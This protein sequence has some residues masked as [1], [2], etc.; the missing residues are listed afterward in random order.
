MSDRVDRLFEGDQEPP[1]VKARTTWILVSLALALP[2]NLMGFISCT[3]VPGAGL[4][5]AAWSMVD[6][7]LSLV[8]SGLI[9]IEQAPQLN[10]LKRVTVATLALSGAVLIVQI[11]LLSTGAYERW[12]L[13]LDGLL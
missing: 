1:P 10:R 12:L 5:L 8:E 7:D 2:L 4:A 11:I 3:A 6:R 13:Q 9:S